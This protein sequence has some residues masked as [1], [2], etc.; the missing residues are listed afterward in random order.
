MSTQH[1]T[2]VTGDIV[3]IPDHLLPA[4]RQA[5]LELAAPLCEEVA[6]AFYGVT[7]DKSEDEQVAMR[8]K[9]EQLLA[10]IRALNAKG[11]V[12]LAGTLIA[13]IVGE[14]IMLQTDR[15]GDSAQATSA[16]A[17]DEL[18]RTAGLVRRLR[19]FDHDLRT[20]AKAA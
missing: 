10:T 4:L 1:A 3:A 14:A 6:E 5:A 20:T 9:L 8:V 18:E 17:F 2:R 11:T 16:E 7:G 15:I 12:A 19:I 13:P